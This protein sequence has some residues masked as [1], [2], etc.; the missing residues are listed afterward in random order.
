VLAWCAQADPARQGAVSAALGAPG[1][2]A[3]DAVRAL[4]RRLGGEITVDSST[5]RGSTF[6]VALPRTLAVEVKGEA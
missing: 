3:A 1:A 2:P 4:V 6:R 5:D